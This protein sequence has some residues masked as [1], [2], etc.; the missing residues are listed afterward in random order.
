MIT[1]FHFVPAQKFDLFRWESL[2]RLRSIEVMVGSQTLGFAIGLS[3][4]SLV[5]PHST[6]AN[7]LLTAAACFLVGV[8]IVAFWRVYRTSREMRA[9]TTPILW[10]ASSFGETP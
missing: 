10:P 8:S 4:P 7:L 3:V 1:D 2:R 6:Q 5:L 9:C